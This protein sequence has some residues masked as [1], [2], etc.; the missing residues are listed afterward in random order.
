MTDGLSDGRLAAIFIAA[1]L[2]TSLATANVAD[3]LVLA[4]SPLLVTLVMML[5]VT[6]E[7]WSRR[8]WERVGILRAG[9]S[10]WV[11]A[12]GSSML[13]SLAA[14]VAV[15]VLGYASFIEPDSEFVSAAVVMAITGPILAFT[16]EIGW[17][18]YLQPRVRRWGVSASMLIVG[19]VWAAWHLPYILLTPYY[20]SEGNRVITLLLFT[21]SAVA[22]SFLFGYLRIASASMWPAV[23][24]HWAHNWTFALLTGYLVQTQHPVVVTEYLSGDTGLFVLIGT[25]IAALIVRRRCRAAIEPVQHA[26]TSVPPAPH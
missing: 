15:V 9:R 24:A 22:F 18:G 6:R 3:G 14:T 19:V 23:L 13:V 10:W 2:V 12:V 25:I 4:L 20:H 17:R 11:V 21:A 7:G 5:L 16:E 26:E 8:G 1:V